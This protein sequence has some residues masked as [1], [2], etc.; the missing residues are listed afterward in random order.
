MTPQK[1]LTPSDCFR[2]CLASILDLPIASVPDFFMGGALSSEDA[3]ASVEDWLNHEGWTLLISCFPP[4][5]TLSEM[6]DYDGAGKNHY[7]LGGGANGKGHCVIVKSGQVIF[8]PG[9]QGLP[10]L[11]GPHPSGGWTLHFIG[12]LL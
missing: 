6:L 9:S 2:A 12:K 11:T 1:Q 5:F 10:G 8:N 4:N 3:Y 7:I